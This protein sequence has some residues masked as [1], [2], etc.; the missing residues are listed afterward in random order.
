LILSS[1][2][3]DYSSLL[4]DSKEVST[5]GIIPTQR[6]QRRGE[7]VNDMLDPEDKFKYTFKEIT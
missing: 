6:V 3:F 5:V 1:L 7:E 2:I 4:E